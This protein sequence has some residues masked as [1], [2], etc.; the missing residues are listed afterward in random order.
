MILKGI[1]AGKKG[2]R[3][4]LIHL[5][6]EGYRIIATNYTSRQGEIDIISSDKCCISFVEFRSKST[7]E[8]GL[9]E[10]TI[11]KRKKNQ[12]QKAALSYIKRNHLEDR[13]CR[14]DVVC[15]ED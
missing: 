12:I 9:P 15:I 8:F 5:K 7:E 4:A 10:Y 2:E 14:F 3:L 13:D 11:N 6:K 1:G